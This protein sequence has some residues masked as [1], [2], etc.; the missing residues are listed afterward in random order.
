VL[1]QLPAN[2][3]RPGPRWPI[4]RVVVPPSG[5]VTLRIHAA[6]GW[7][8]LLTP[9]EAGAYMT[10]IIATPVGTERVVPLREACG[11]YVDWYT[12]PARSSTP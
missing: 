1:R 11:R 2:L 12:T 5:S 3:D 6:N 4:G 8:T 10:S 9:A 7:F